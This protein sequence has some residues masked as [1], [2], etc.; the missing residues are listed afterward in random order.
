MPKCV[1]C[2]YTDITD[3]EFD[4]SRTICEA[5]SEKGYKAVLEYINYQKINWCIVTEPGSSYSNLYYSTG[6]AMFYAA[7]ASDALGYANGKEMNG[8][9]L[10]AN[11]IREA[12]HRWKKSLVESNENKRS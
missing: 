7:A 2:G 11:K 5:C 4:W 12:Y 10:N 3:A 8:D 6:S 1:K 9:L